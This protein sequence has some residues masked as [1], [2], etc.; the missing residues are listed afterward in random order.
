MKKFPVPFFAGFLATL[1]FAPAATTVTFVVGDGFELNGSDVFTGNNPPTGDDRDAGT[2]TAEVSTVY[3]VANGSFQDPFSGNDGIEDNDFDP[4]SVGDISFSNGNIFRAGFNFNLSSLD[5]SDLGPGQSFRVTSIELFVEV[6][7][8]T[9]TTGV[10]NVA[11][12]LGG[13]NNGQNTSV[14]VNVFANADITAQN[15][16]LPSTTFS[17]NSSDEAALNGNFFAPLSFSSPETLLNLG[18]DSNFQ[19]VLNTSNESNPNAGAVFGSGL[20]EGSNNPNGDNFGT[21]NIN[22]APVLRITAE[23][24][25]EPTVF[26]LAGCASL[27]LLLRRKR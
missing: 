27:I 11:A 26:T 12:G 2:S 14:S 18:S 3:N 8:A 15:L 25:P 4:V 6:S 16:G 1:S 7:G 21:G 5:L 20:A 10:N 22:V 9:F 17:I 24:I 13:N 23:V 19:V